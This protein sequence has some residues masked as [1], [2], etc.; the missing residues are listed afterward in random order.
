MPILDVEIVLKPGEALGGG[1]AKELAQ[2]ASLV[3]GTPPGRTW[4]KLRALAPDQYA[5]NGGGPPPGVYP[6]F[7]SVLKARLPS[8]DRLAREATGLTEAVAKACHRSPENVHVLYQPE[9]AG[10]VTFGGE[11]VA[12]DQ[13]PT[14][15]QSQA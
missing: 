6:V 9:A 14:P 5:E 11:P 12:G 7:V 3:L 8:P 4:V 10:R 1:L 15:G 2:E 13:K